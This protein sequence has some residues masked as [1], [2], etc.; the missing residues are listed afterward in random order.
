ME[1]KLNRPD[2]P[3][4]ERWDGFAGLDT[5]TKEQAESL[6]KYVEMGMPGMARVQDRMSDGE[7]G[8]GWHSVMLEEMQGVGLMKSLMDLGSKLDNLP[9]F[10]KY[11]LCI[12]YGQ[13]SFYL[14]LS[15]HKYCFEEGVRISEFRKPAEFVLAEVNKRFDPIERLDFDAVS[16]G[17]Q[18]NELHLYI[19]AGLE[20]DLEC[21]LEGGAV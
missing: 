15:S 2:V 12:E 17:F 10:G 4:D 1:E 5:L 14:V 16:I 7:H 19:R 8:S 3:L 18:D 21:Y 13:L 20:H 6:E 9:C 11:H